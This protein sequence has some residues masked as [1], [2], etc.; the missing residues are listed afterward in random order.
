MR[1]DFNI[2][3]VFMNSKERFLSAVRREVP[4]IVPVAP[5]I[6]DRFAC[7]LL[8]Q[9]GWKA[10][11]EVHKMVGSIWF[12]GPLGIDFDVKWPVGWAH[13][14]RLIKQ[15]GT[16]RVREDIIKTPSGK[17]TSKVV[18]GMVP[19]DPDLQ[20]TI[21]YHIKTKKD[22]EIYRAYLEEWLKR[23]EP[24]IRQ[25][26]EAYNTM[27]SEGVP[28][29]GAGCPFDD[30]CLI[31]GPEN[32]LGDLYRRPEVVREVLNLLREA[33][34]KEVEAFIESPSEV[35]CYWAWGAYDMSPGHFRDWILPD[36]KKTADAVR[37]EAKY[38]GFWFSGKV[39]DFLPMAVEANPH[40]IEPFE[41]QSNITLREAK[42]LYG[43]KVCVMGNFDPVLL[44]FGTRRDAERET[45]R[46]LAE[47][48]VG[49]GYVLVTGDEV[50]ANAKIGNLRT[51]V[52][53]VEKHG[54]Y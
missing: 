28:S 39:R 31:R 46:C 13:K 33:K 19:S 54:R 44:A 23:A 37:K 47:G 12:R 49:G 40:F 53:T 42:Q 45:L 18:Y 50:P 34:V 24:N 6:H 15:K 20:R 43:K 51:M 27:G 26:V 16:R 36:L 52:R 14:S 38:V 1:V 5:L 22:Y 25:V 7:K 8:G 17:I 30:L 41:L 35:L 2:H 29:V 3:G 48:M 21:E 9:T 4:D 32:L 10:V 11:F